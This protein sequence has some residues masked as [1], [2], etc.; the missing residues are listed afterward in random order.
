MNCLVSPA[1]FLQLDSNIL[2]HEQIWEFEEVHQRWLPLVE[3]GLPEDKG[4]RVCAVAWAPNIGRLSLQTSITC[5]YAHI[6]F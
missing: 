1:R 2:K 5:L 3:L 6:A 4:D